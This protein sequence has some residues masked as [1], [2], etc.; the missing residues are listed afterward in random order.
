[1]ERELWKII[2]A[3]ITFLD[4]KLPVG[5]YEH[6]VGRIV[7]VYLWAVLHDRPTYW[8]CDKRNWSGVRP[9]EQL[10]DQSTMSRRIFRDDTQQM[11]EQLARRLDATPAASLLRFVDGK[12]L[13]VSKHSLDR[14]ATFGRGA[15]GQDRGY[16]FHAIYGPSNQPVAWS[17]T[18]LNVCEH[19]QA[20]ELIK[21]GIGPGYLLGDANYDANQL[22]EIAGQRQVRLLT[23]RRYASAKGLGH[24]RHSNYR[25]D[26]ITRLEGPSDFARSLLKQRRRIETRF[27]H[28]TNFGG[29]LTCIPPWVRGL[30]RVS[31]W[32]QAKIIIRLARDTHLRRLSA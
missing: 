21:Q 15:G 9:P 16:K 22:H 6:S 27:A 17:V 13:P 32:V 28:L 18:P 3:N 31:L 20:A 25:R 1:M 26:A 5:D 8:A 24:H 12:P 23:P 30:H 29:G 7:R 10:P 4:R 2:S 19:K 11:L 14:Q